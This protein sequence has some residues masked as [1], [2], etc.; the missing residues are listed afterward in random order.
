MTKCQKCLR[1]KGFALNCSECKGVF[2][3]GCIQLELHECP[4]LV[5]KVKKDLMILEVKNQKVTAQKV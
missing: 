3:T 5:Q 1:K 4:G 2:C